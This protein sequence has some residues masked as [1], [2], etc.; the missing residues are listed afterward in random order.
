MWKCAGVA[1]IVDL[2]EF[3]WWMKFESVAKAWG[4]LQKRKWGESRWQ[5]RR[6]VRALSSRDEL[7]ANTRLDGQIPE[8]KVEEPKHQI[9]N[10]I[11]S[12]PKTTISQGPRWL[13]CY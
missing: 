4:A 11:A 12:E 13:V 8:R 1:R 5:V 3:G 9:P 10:W 2:E 7:P 6:V